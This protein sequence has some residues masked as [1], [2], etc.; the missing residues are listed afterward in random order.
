MTLFETLR[1]VLP[2]S[3][4]T[5]LGEPPRAIEVPHRV[6]ELIRAREEESERLIGWVQLV[7]TA[8]FAALYVI[9]PRPL[10]AGMSMLA[11]VPL[12]LT[13]YAAFTAARL[14]FAHRGFLPGWL[15]VLS[16][17][18]D[19][20]LLLGLI[21]AFHFQYEQ[22]AAFSLKV[23]TFVYIFAFIALRA[24]RFDHRYVLSAGLFAAAG[25]AL[26]VILAI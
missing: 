23:P 14:W 10:D 5:H 1:N 6:A 25:W 19:T 17:L 8:T 24:L 20:A 2:R 3:L 21:W 13:G 18:V 16:M 11:P 22:P 12:A 15:L 4:F 26:L 7:M 9:A